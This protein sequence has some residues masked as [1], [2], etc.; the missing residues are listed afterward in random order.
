L[1]QTLYVRFFDAAAKPLG[2]AVAAGTAE[3][4]FSPVSMAFDKAGNLLVL[5]LFRDFSHA[6]EIDDLQIQLLDPQGLALGPPESVAS[7]ASA[8]YSQPSQGSVAWAGDS[9]LVTW[10]ASGPGLTSAI[11]VRRFAAH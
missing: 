2:P 3:N 6:P 4:A 10:T 9:W 11:F 5:C 8:P 7:A 1:S